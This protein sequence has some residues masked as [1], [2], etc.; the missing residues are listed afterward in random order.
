M[1]FLRE[2]GYSFTEMGRDGVSFL[3]TTTTRFEDLIMVKISIVEV[4]NHTFTF[5]YEVVKEETGDASLWAGA[6]LH[7]SLFPSI[8]YSQPGTR[9]TTSRALELIPAHIYLLGRY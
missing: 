4:R 6:G 7:S 9:P 5:E 2:L 1:E 3:I 8:H